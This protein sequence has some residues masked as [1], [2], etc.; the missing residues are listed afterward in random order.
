M[1]D[2][3]LSS[4]TLR[5]F[6]DSKF[7]ADVKRLA[8]RLGV[9]PWTPVGR[10]YVINVAEGESYSIT[11]LVHAFLDRMEAAGTPESSEGYLASSEPSESAQEDTLGKA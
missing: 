3:E 8:E 1:T 11:D 10:A 7:R 5:N 2:F 9:K 6:D 4:F